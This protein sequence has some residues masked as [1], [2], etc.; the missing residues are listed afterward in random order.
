LKQAVANTESYDAM[1]RLAVE[2]SRKEDIIQA[3]ASYSTS[4]ADYERMKDLLES[5][6][7]TQKQY[8]DTYARYITAQQTYEKMKHGSRPEEISNAKQR[9]ESAAALA[10]LLRK[11]IRDCHIVAP[12]EGTI[13]LRSVEPGEFVTVGT[14]VLRLTY[15]DKVKLMIYLNEEEVGK[16][17]LGDKAEVYI[18][19]D[20][21][22]SHDG[23]IVYISPNAEFTP[24]NVQ[25]KEERTKLV[26]GVKVEV[27]NAEGAL[28][29][30]LPADA[31]ITTNAG[32]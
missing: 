7:I 16:V 31:V 21:K 32:K 29:P 4:K 24:K 6:T 1:Y 19:S 25:T 23:K 15:L 3:E 28:K 8:D 18:D 9:R 5:H 20:P 27:M 26:F 10:D 30:G 17:H 12:S 11:K 13:T 14:G 22:K 2:G